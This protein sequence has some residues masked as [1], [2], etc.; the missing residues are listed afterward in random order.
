MEIAKVGPDGEW[1]N[2]TRGHRCKPTHRAEPRTLAELRA[3]L[4]RA[5]RV[6]QRVRVV[7]S[8]HSYSDVALAPE[9]QLSLRRMDAVE[10]VDTKR[11]VVRVQGGI[12]V[13]RL[14][15]VLADN[16]LGFAN[17]GDTDGQ[18]IAG[19]LS[20]GT[21]GTGLRAPAFSGQVEALSVMTADG[22]V[23]EASEEKDPELFRAARVSLGALGV[24][25]GVTLRARPKYW[26]RRTDTIL[27]REDALRLVADP[28]PVD[29]VGVWFM[30]YADK[31]V[32]WQ[33]ERLSSPTEAPPSKLE[34]WL[35]DVLQVNVGLGVAGF[36]G[37]HFPRAVPGLDRVFASSLRPDRRVDR[38]DNV[39]IRP[40][41]IRHDAFAYAVPLERGADA[42]R[43]LLE[44]IERT[45]PA[46]ILPCEIRF[47]G[48]DDA[49]LHPQHGRQTAWIGSA[50]HAPGFDV[51]PCWSEVER[52][53][54]DLGGRPHW[55]KWHTRT[56]AMLAPMY[57]RW[58][59]F[60]A[61]RARLDPEGR[62][63]SPAIDRLL[64]PV[65]GA[66]A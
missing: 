16:G 1:Q 48:A 8:G 24:L 10:M 23:L 25:V 5:K 26:L 40:I 65:R 46:G 42:C 50:M 57:P 21:H 28:P 64:G 29:H 36:V 47:A 4:L 22:E 43:A 38:G 13:S 7:G 61:L 66:R 27:S 9:T 44:A 53:C 15:T 20:T 52:A 14:R 33:S 6:G 39:F 34:Q 49:W 60:Q 3:E 62:F 58:G 54:L 45:R 35:K 30:P 12:T 59:D 19:A 2:F 56:A 11:G 18:S 41:A 55:A 17:M 31:A 37:R 32:V 51:A 63:G